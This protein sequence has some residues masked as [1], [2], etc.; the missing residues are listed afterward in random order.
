M[1]M[2][3]IE[4]LAQV[5]RRFVR[6]FSVERHHRSGDARN[7]DDVRAPAFFGDPRHLD[8]KGSAADDFFETMTHDVMYAGM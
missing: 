6:G 4:P 8:D 3:A 7:L 2:R 1:L 5:G